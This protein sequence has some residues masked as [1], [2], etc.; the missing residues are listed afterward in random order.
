MTN[1]EELTD[2][3]RE[4]RTSLEALPEVTEPSLPTDSHFRYPTTRK[5]YDVDQSRLPESYFE[6]L[7]VAFEEHLP[8]V[9]VIDKILD[10]AT[11][12]IEDS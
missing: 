4:L 2:R 3:S 8:V 7:A 9:E 5:Q 12:N 10:E 11:S 6:T 1:G